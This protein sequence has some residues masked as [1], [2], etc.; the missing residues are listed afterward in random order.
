MHVLKSLEGDKVGNIIVYIILIAVIAMAVY[1][2]VKRIRHGSS[3]CGERE[4]APKKIRVSD[5]NKKNYPYIYELKVDGMHCSNCARRIEN[6]FNANDGMWATA[7]ISQKTV[8]LLTKEPVEE[9]TC[10]QI[11]SDSGYTL[12]S[13]KEINS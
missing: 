10:R 6:G 4:A 11:T 1:G 7:D 8:R 13:F 12:I 3:C 9:S 2:T 5:R